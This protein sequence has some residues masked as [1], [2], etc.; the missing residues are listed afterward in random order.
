MTKYKTLKACMAFAL[1]SSFCTLVARADTMTLFIL[2]QLDKPVDEEAVLGKV[3][4]ISLGNCLVANA[5]SLGS[6]QI[7]ARIQCDDLLKDAGPKALADIGRLENVKQATMFS[8]S[9]P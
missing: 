4:S 6:D 7:V 5:V 1:M 2:I 3:R 9:K 8:V